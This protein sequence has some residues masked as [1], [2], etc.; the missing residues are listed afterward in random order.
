[1]KVLMLSWEYPPHNV[2][3]LGKHVTELIPMLGKVGVEVHLVT[4]RV[5]GGPAEETICPVL[6]ERGLAGLSKV[7][8]VDSPS[9]GA[10]NFFVNA[11]QTNTALEQFA[12]SLWDTEGPFDI[13]HVHDWLV[14]FA[15]VALKH[16]YRT[17]LL[18]TIHATEHGRGRGTV[19]GDVPQAINNVEWWLTYEAWRVVCCSGFMANEVQTALRT[20][21]DKVDVIP[22]GIDTTRFDVLANEDLS[23]FRAGFASP[24][25]KILFYVGRVVY[26]KGV[27][28]LVQAMPRLIGQGRHVKLVVAGTGDHLNDVRQQAQRLGVAGSSYFTGFIPDATRD[29]LFKVADVAVFPSLY[30]PFGIV[31]LEA[32]AARTPVVVSEVGGLTE[33]VKHGET[34]VTVYQNDV[35]SLVWGIEHTLDHPDWAQQRAALA[36]QVVVEQFN[37]KAIAVKTNEVYER[38]VAERQSTVWT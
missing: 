17:P 9:T 22:N 33:V 21:A 6:D 29:R 14:A 27:H 38:I 10:P 18:A 13:I 25:E 26:E 4:P 37:W 3:G 7:Y 23:D 32:M 20:P 19:R 2:G 11:T 12:R 15:G 5:A 24:D 31:A 36:Y 16:A 28:L 35:S 30:E 8:R 34:G 1:M